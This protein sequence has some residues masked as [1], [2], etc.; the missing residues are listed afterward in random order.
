MLA[1]HSGYAESDIKDLANDL[2]HYVKKVEQSSL[3][4]IRRIYSTPKM[5][6]VAKMIQ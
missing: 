5:M 3:K 2:H 4:T 1:K 6:E